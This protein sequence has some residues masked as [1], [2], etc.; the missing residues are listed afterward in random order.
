MFICAMAGVGCAISAALIC[1]KSFFCNTSMSETDSLSSCSWACG[2]SV[3]WGCASASWTRR[4]AGGGF[5]RACSGSGTESS[6]CFQ[7]SAARKNRSKAWAKISACSWRLTKIDSSV[8]K[9]SARLPISITRSAFS[10]SIT[11]PGP[12]GIPAARSARAK[13][14]TLSATRPRAARVGGEKARALAGIRRVGGVAADVVIK[15]ESVRVQ[16]RHGGFR[17]LSPQERG[18]GADRRCGAFHGRQLILALRLFQNLLQRVALHPRDV[19]LVFQER[20]ER[21]AHHLRR[22]RAG[23]EFGQRGG[24]VDGLGYPRR[25]IEI[26][27]AQR[28]HEADDLLRQFCGNAGHARFDDRELALGTGIIHPVIK[29][30]ALQRVVN[31]AGA[32]R[33][34]D[35]DRR[36]RRLDGAEFGY[37]HLEVAENFE[38]ISLECL[39]GAIEFV[40]QQHRRAGHLRLQRLQQRPFDQIAFGENVAGKLVAIGIAGSFREPDR[41]HLRRA[42]PLIDRGGDI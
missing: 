5:F 23:V 31:L 27:L 25:L 20:A 28:L 10:A 11:A 1:A 15:G 9:T 22:Q 24:P 16:S 40:D 32:V 14:R 36:L 38:Q 13:P 34:D 26:L 37:R 6:M 7:S 17:H 18:E 42:V 29:T 39:V 41:D 8:V 3:M 12:T 30:A 33:G 2:V 4:E 19:I 21:I 35:D